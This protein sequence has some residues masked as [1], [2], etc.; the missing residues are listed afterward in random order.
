M[1]GMESPTHR[2]GAGLANAIEEKWQER[3]E[4]EGTYLAPNPT[5]GLREPNARLASRDPFY[6]LDMFPYPSGSGLPSVA[7][8]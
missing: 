5:G 6:V 4:L 2:Y 8:A 7:G 1:G 3:W